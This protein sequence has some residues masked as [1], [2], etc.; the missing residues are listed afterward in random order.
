MGFVQC[1]A[2]TL[3]CKP[4]VLGFVLLEKKKMYQRFNRIKWTIHYV[5]RFYRQ[6]HSQ[7]YGN[8]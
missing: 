1:L 4:E 5:C 8:E 7:I 3:L 6:T 2:M